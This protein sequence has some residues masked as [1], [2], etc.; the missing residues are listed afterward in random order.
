MPD[1]TEL[2]SVIEELTSEFRSSI[3]KQHAEIAA[4]G[5]TSA[6]TVESITKTNDALCLLE[7]Q[8]ASMKNEVAT[9]QDMDD[10]FVRLSRPGEGGAQNIDLT[11][12]AFLNFARTG[13]ADGELLKKD[14]SSSVGSEGGFLVG[15]TLATQINS[16]VLDACPMRQ[17]ANVVTIGT[18]SF[19]QNT[20]KT[21]GSGG[22]VSEKGTRSETTALTFGSTLI[23]VHELYAMPEATSQFLADSQANIESWLI[24]EIGG[25]LAEIENDAFTV[26]SGAGKPK[27]ILGYTPTADSSYAWG[28]PG[29]ILSGGAGDWASSTPAA[30]VLNLIYALATPYH[31]GASFM[32]PRAV[33]GELRSKVIGTDTFLF[34]P[35]AAGQVPTFA[36]FP[37]YENPDLAAKGSNSYSLVFGN[38]AKAYTIV[39]RVGISVLRN[40]FATM[41]SVLF[42]TSKRV[43]GDVT[44]FEAYKVMKFA[45]S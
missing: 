2:T 7:K 17:L 33:I 12:A 29:Y 38:W 9:K 42:Y 36:G 39:D 24:G 22:W 16:I 18:D 34:Q 27:G 44:N 41:G 4:N 23:P 32:A 21:K 5:R 28:A 43:G 13:F 20:K 25:E 37:V 10:M 40:P 14:L 35:G 8:V 45:S 19:R 3:K 26:G 1:L 15:E 31:S 6:D 30:N 11:K